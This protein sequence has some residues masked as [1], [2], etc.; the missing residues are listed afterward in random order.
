MVHVPQP[1]VVAQ[2]EAADHR[3]HDDENHRHVEIGPDRTEIM[4]DAGHDVLAVEHADLGEQADDQPQLDVDLA[5]F[6]TLDRADQGLGKLV[7]DIGG[8]RH[9]RRRAQRHHGR[10]Q[11]RKR[12]PNR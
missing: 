10:R 4:L 11:R 6:V 7:A 9:D 8:Y 12:R 5:I 3:Q 1:A 2:H